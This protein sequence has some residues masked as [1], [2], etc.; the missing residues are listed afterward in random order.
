[1]LALVPL[2]LMMDWVR[3]FKVKYEPRSTLSFPEAK[4]KL[5]SSWD[6]WNFHDIVIID[7]NRCQWLYEEFNGKRLDTSIMSG[8][9]GPTVQINVRARGKF[10]PDPKGTRCLQL[11]VSVQN[12]VHSS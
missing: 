5:V 7:R 11:P 10:V 6:R 2:N 1:N 8:K 3:T 9:T 4:L 12:Q